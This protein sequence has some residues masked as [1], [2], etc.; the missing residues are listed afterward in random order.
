MGTYKVDAKWEAEGDSRLYRVRALDT[1]TKRI[2]GQV[3]VHVDISVDSDLQHHLGTAGIKSVEL[4][5][6]ELLKKTIMA[7]Y[8]GEWTPT[9]T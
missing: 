8:G 2:L 6:S 1:S 5:A 4:G 3:R 7:R 9:E